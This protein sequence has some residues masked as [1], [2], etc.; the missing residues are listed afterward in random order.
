M[1][2]GD[3][4]G[5]LERFLDGL[6]RHR[7]VARLALLEDLFGEGDELRVRR[8][9]L[10][11]RFQVL[12]AAVRLEEIRD[13]LLEPVHARLDAE[14]EPVVADLGVRMRR[15]LVQLRQRE[16]DCLICRTRE[17]L[18]VERPL[19]RV[20]LGTH[21]HGRDEALVRVLVNFVEPRRLERHLRVRHVL[22]EDPFLGFDRFECAGEFL[23]RER[24]ELFRRDGLEA[25]RRDVGPHVQI[26]PFTAHVRLDRFEEIRA[27]L[28]R[29]AREHVVRVDAVLVE[30][31]LAVVRRAVLVEP[32]QVALELAGHDGSLQVCGFLAPHRFHDAERG[33][34]GPAL[35]QPEVGPGRVGDE[36]AGPGV[37]QLVRHHPD[38]RLVTRHE[39]RRNE[40]ERGVFHAAVGERARHHEDVE[41]S[42]LVLP[43]ELLG[44]RHDLRHVL[45]FDRRLFDHHRFRPDFG[46]VR[47][48]LRHQ[49]AN[50]ERDEVG[51]DR[52]GH[53]PLFVG[54]P[55][56][57]ETPDESVSGH[58][59]T[60][61]LRYNERCRVGHAH[62]R[63]VLTGHVRA[64]VDRFTLAEQERV[65][66]A[67]RLLGGE[68]L[69][70]R[71]LLR[72]V[73]DHDP[74]VLGHLEVEARAEDGVLFA[75]CEGDLCESAMFDDR[76]DIQLAGVER[77]FARSIERE[78]DSS[79]QC[80]GRK[81]RSEG[82][83]QVLERRM[84]IGTVK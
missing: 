26:E 18:E 80:P 8:E 74:A 29:H 45:E 33:P 53:L 2:R 50:G 41:A 19:R 68:P 78:Y 1:L 71:C 55:I 32:L 9:R 27:L 63:R 34:L 48:I 76:R 35:V 67:A 64:S 49:V 4:L 56:F 57:Y 24:Q 3:F 37:G 10:V 31:Q 62:R 59:P 43:E 54:F 12:H 81:D 30:V 16:K 46:A 21:L 14:Q 7:V 5:L 52:L 15:Q 69:Q 20:P 83:S 17:V 6:L 77:D 25:E 13:G 60:E 66:L 75:E 84:L 23:A 40:G 22:A 39:R 42:P 58:E 11:E 44:L 72:I 70:T 38:E 79:D 73:V 82:D 61:L 65:P 28:V 47:D 51:S 36:V